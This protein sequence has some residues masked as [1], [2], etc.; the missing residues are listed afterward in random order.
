M[1]RIHNEG[2]QG[3]GFELPWKCKYCLIALAC[4][5]VSRQMSYLPPPQMIVSEHLVET[6]KGIE[7]NLNNRELDW[8]GLFG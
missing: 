3:E 8:P 2:G 6:Y 5:K 7:G 1:H 4:R